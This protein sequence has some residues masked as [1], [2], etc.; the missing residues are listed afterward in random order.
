M[1]ISRITDDLLI[2]RTPGP[3]DFE[4]LHEMGVRLV[5][6]M[7][8]WPGSRPRAT[9]PELQYLRLRTFDSPLAPI[10][11]ATLIRGARAALRV[12]E[13]GGRVYTH[14]SRGRHRSVAMAAAILIAQGRSPEEAMALI[15]Q[16][17]PDADPGAAHIRSRILKFD[18]TWK[19][20]HEAEP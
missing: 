3:A 1:D 15:K 19:L 10:P 9:N 18:Q 14:C 7:R 12:I 20:V 2:G 6:N 5:I 13:D 17:R 16:N 11:T 8:F 4:R